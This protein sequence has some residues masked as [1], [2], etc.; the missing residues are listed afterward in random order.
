MIFFRNICVGL[1]V[2]GMFFCSCRKKGCKDPMSLSYNSEA[3]KDDG[4]CTYPENIKR[5][6]VFKAT[7]TWCE[8]CG[9]LGKTFSDDIT[10][11]Y[12]NAQIIELHRN[13]DLSSNVGSLLRAHLD[14]VNSKNGVPSFYVG[15]ERIDSNYYSLLSSSVNSETSE[16]SE[17]NLA[18]NHNFNDNIFNVNIH[19]QLANGFNGTS[20]YLAVYIIEDELVKSQEIDGYIDPATG[21]NYNSNFTHNYILRA[22]ANASGSAFGEPIVFR[23]DGNNIIS[24]NAINLQPSTVWNYNNLYIVAVIWQKIGDDFRFL[25]FIRS[26][27]LGS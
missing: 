1:I 10:S 8:Q 21:T 4:S 9:D 26:T 12:L 17:V 18:I 13:D 15:T 3:K 20:C 24:Y 5:S 22:E 19:S 11:T 16:L 25:N 23:P 27:N 2:F 14:S 7:A 6:L